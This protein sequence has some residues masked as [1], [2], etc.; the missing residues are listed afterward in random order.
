VS[1]ILMDP[2][3]LTDHEGEQKQG[4]SVVYYRTYKI[5]SQLKIN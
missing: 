4:P 2:A 1:V 5:A 3:K